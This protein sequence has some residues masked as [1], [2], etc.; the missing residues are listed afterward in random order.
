MQ[1][2]II[3]IL[4]S[5]LYIVL[6]FFLLLWCQFIKYKEEHGKSL[7]VTRQQKSQITQNSVKMDF[8]QR[9][10]SDD[11]YNQ[12]VDNIKINRF[13]HIKTLVLSYN[14]VTDKRLEKLAEDINPDQLPQLKELDLSNNKITAQSFENVKKIIENLPNLQTLNLKNNEIYYKGRDYTSMEDLLKWLDH[15]NY[16]VRDKRSYSVVTILYET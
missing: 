10:K 9:L 5:I 3:V 2:S 14:E 1:N 13:N 16:R 7:I 6:V 11:D 12:I 4:V 8:K 15:Q